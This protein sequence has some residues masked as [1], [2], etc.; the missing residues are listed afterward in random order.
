M[1]SGRGGREPRPGRGRRGVCA[2]R[3]ETGL[4]RTASPFSPGKTKHVLWTIDEHVSFRPRYEMRDS[5]PTLRVRLRRLRP[6]AH[7]PDACSLPPRPESMRSGEPHALRA[8]AAGLRAGLEGAARESWCS[9][10]GGVF[11]RCADRPHLGPDAHHPLWFRIVE[12]QVL[13]AVAVR[14]GAGVDGPARE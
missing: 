5:H 4:G 10:W 7:E 3:A 13:R 8:V 11:L 12:P 9:W 14:A 6:R 1:D 2:R